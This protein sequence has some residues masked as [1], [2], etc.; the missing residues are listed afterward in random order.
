MTHDPLCPYRPARSG[1]CD[2]PFRDPNIS[3]AVMHVSRPEIPCQC[4]LIAKVRADERKKA[5]ARVAN[6]TYW[7]DGWPEN[8][9]VSRISAIYAAEGEENE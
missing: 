5:G 8:V 3:C 2:R 6:I 4:A 9:V 1:A 7:E